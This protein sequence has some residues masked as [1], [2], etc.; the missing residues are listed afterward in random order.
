VR[1]LLVGVLLATACHSPDPVRVGSKPFAENRVLAEL[2]ARLIEEAG[3]PVERHL[4]FGDTPACREAVRSGALDLYP[5]YVGTALAAL[6]LPAERD[7]DA[8]FALLRDRTADLDLAWPVRLGFDN[9]YVV[10]TTPAVAARGGLQRLSDLAADG[11]RWRVATSAE[12]T[13]RPVDGFDA[14]GRFYGLPAWEATVIADDPAR[15]HGALLAGEV[16][17]MVDDATS[18]WIDE[19]G[20][21]VLGDDLGFF[22]AYD[23]APAV[24]RRTAAARPRLGQALAPLEGALSLAT[25]RAANRSVEIDGVD[26]RAAAE[27]I[28][29]AM[30]QIDAPAPDLVPPLRVAVAPGG[31]AARL[32]GLAVKAVREGTPGWRVAVTPQEAPVAALEELQLAVVAAPALFEAPA[33]SGRARPREDVEALAALGHLAV[34]WIGEA[35]GDVAR[36]GVGPA[37]SGADSVAAALAAA[38]GWD[39]ERVPGEREA[40]LA[41]LDA[42]QLDAV[43]ILDEVG[44]ASPTLALREP[45][46]VLQ[47]IDGWAGSDRGFRWPF[48]RAARIPAGAYPGQ[49]EAV[50]TL[51]TQ[52]VL[53]GPR[54]RGAPL[55]GGGPASAL[56]AGQGLTDATVARIREALAGVPIDPVLPR[57]RVE[58]GEGR[59]AL[60]LQPGVTA[61]N[62]GA[63]VFLAWLGWLLG[64]PRPPVPMHQK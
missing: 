33:G 22:P 31:E 56:E 15:R 34:H 63:F 18:P 44:A 48:L 36:L 1:A 23:A 17:L 50:P 26:P 2:M 29:V 39:L 52:V 47:P 6:G 62:L 43:L 27:G 4:D 25:I 58:R 11:V 7:G 59:G 12:F 40:Q 28:L 41:Q 20:L 61:A 13:E 9:P 38:Y 32:V 5:E 64:R 3:L 60:P 54:R 16:D 8:A 55:G 10:V 57:P 24:N 53:V 49:P 45:G 14:L 51:T 30:E 37:G 35:P 21:V 19:Y 42:G 46:R